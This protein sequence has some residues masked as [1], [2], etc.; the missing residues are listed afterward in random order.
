MNT[1]THAPVRLIASTKS[2]I[3]GEAVRQ[4]YAAAELDGVQEVVGFPDLH[5]GRG[6]PVGAAI[7]TQN[8]IYPHLAGG[9][10]G[11][12]IGLWSTDLLRRKAKL[13]RWAEMRFDLEHP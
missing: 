11:C 3:E 9:D 2:W 13:D 10:I 5:P 4:L 12:G 6:Y 1:I 8:V 7:I